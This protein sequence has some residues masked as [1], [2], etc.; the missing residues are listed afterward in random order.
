MKIMSEDKKIH[1]EISCY[2]FLLEEG[3]RYKNMYTID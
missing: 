1:H 3:E 2:F